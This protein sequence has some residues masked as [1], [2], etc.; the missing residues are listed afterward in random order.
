MRSRIALVAL[1]S[2]SLYASDKTEAP[3]LKTEESVK[4]LVENCLKHFVAGE[5]KAGLDLFKPYWV[6]PTNE[7]DTLI[8]QTVST[9]N[10]VRERFGNSIGYE[11]ISQQRAGKSFLRI[12]AVE[13]LQN[14]AI[15]YSIVFYKADDNWIVQNFNWDDKIQLLFGE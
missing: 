12:V 2:L 10:T 4:I 6:A 3:K 14:T 8:M 7:I 9:R 13:K 1:I 5:Y 11:F 15:R